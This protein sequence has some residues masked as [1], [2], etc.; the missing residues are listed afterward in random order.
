MEGAEIYGIAHKKGEAKITLCSVKDKPGVGAKMIAPLAA[1]EIPVDMI[2]QNVS[3]DGKSTDMTFTVAEEDLERAVNALKNS[4]D[5]EAQEII[6]SPN[7]ARV[8]V[9]G[10][11]VQ[12]YAHVAETMFK[13]LASIGVNMHAISTSEIRI[14]VLID[15]E[16]IEYAV[17]SL[18]KAF[19]VEA[20]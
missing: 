19:D 16:H 11:G 9:V 15:D 6:T 12:S 18:A 1:E 7:L 17:R 3:L 5:F 10:V 13:T 14:S 20:V 8:S 2:V 4:G